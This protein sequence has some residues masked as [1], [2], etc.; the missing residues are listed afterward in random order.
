[1]TSQKQGKKVKNL[2][3]AQQVPQKHR[4]TSKKEQLSEFFMKCM[5]QWLKEPFFSDKTFK[6]ELHL[7]FLQLIFLV[8]SNEEAIKGS[9]SFLMDFLQQE[10]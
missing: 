6:K 7:T 3:Q 2:P 4:E 5:T 1:M 9:F 8:Y 10:I